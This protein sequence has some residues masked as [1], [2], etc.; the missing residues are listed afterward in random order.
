M[1]VVDG[2]C[3]WWVTVGSGGVARVLIAVHL[4]LN[5]RVLLADLINDG[6]SDF[7]RIE[8]RVDGTRLRRFLHR[9]NFKELVDDLLLLDSRQEWLSLV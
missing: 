5:H 1:K 4:R 9:G 6:S 7:R 8:I 2:A 3:S